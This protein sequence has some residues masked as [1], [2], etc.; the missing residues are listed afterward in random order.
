MV[1]K[2]SLRHCGGGEP[3]PELT[4][5]EPPDDMTARYDRTFRLNRFSVYVCAVVCKNSLRHCG[6]TSLNEGGWGCKS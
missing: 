1:C 6:D 4:A 3:P 2:N 5:G